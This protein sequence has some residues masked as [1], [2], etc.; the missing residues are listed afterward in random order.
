MFKIIL[1]GL[2]IGFGLIAFGGAT[3]VA[4]TTSSAPSVY[5]QCLNDPNVQFQAGAY[6]Q[7]YPN[8]STSQIMHTLCKD[9]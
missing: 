5:S 9:K 1:A 3:P 8:L 4:S 7:K 6:K 2:V